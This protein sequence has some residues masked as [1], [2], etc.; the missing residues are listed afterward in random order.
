[1]KT[2]R[3]PRKRLAVIKTH[4]VIVVLVVLVTVLTSHSIVVVVVASYLPQPAAWCF[5]C[6]IGASKPLWHLLLSHCVIVVVVVA[7]LYVCI[8]MPFVQCVFA[9]LRSFVR[10]KWHGVAKTPNAL[11]RPQKT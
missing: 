4:C 8:I 1:M 3:E 9:A 5:R 6:G 7:C 2:S 10:L 11:Q